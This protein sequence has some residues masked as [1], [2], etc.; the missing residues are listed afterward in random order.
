MAEYAPETLR[1]RW[2]ALREQNPKLRIRDAAARLNVTEAQLLALGVGETATRL[3]DDWADLLLELFRL[4]PLMGLTRNDHAVHERHGAYRHLRV[5]GEVRIV[6]DEGFEAALFLAQWR[7]GF[8]V[9][10]AGHGKVRQSLQFFAEDGSAVHKIYLTEHSRP[11]ILDDLVEHFRSPEQTDWLQIQPRPRNISSDASDRLGSGG[12]ISGWPVSGEGR[13][14]TQPDLNVRSATLNAVP[15]AAGAV[16]SVLTHAASFG[17]PL[18]IAVGNSGAMQL[19]R[20]PIHNVL[21]TGPWINVLDEP[22]NLHL[23]DAA[24]ASAWRIRD[25]T[26]GGALSLCGCDEQRG[27]LLQIFS[28]DR[29]GAW[30]DCVNAIELHAGAGGAA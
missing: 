7:I 18:I 8:A 12:I 4:G 30:E 20:G 14:L 2:H 10:E 22:F 26:P 23:R 6:E 17:I 19:H 27:S 28:E 1:S 5:M 13:A 3:R 16:E 25:L 21:R 29:S 11:G 9:K 24:L 15:L